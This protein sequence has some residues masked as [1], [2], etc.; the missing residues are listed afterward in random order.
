MFKK[1]LSAL[2]LALAL[3]AA[4]ALPA[5]AE[6]PAGPLPAEADQAEAVWEAAGSNEPGRPTLGTQ[7]YLTWAAPVTSC[8]V[9]QAS[10]YMAVEL[11]QSGKA[12]LVRYFDDAFRRTSY[13]YVDISGEL[14]LYGGFYAG[15]GGSCYLVT[16]QNN[17]GQNDQTEV[18]RVTKYDTNWVRKGAAS[19]RGANTTRPFEAGSLRMAEYG[20][21]LYIRTCHEMYTV[22]GENHQAN[23]T[24][25]V[26]T[27]NMTVTGSAT[28]VSYPGKG[29]ISHS[30]NQFILV[31]DAG[32]LVALDHSDASPR[33]AVLGRYATK[34]NGSNPLGSQY[35]YAEIRSFEG[36][37]GTNATGAS[38]GGLEYSASNYLAAGNYV[39]APTMYFSNVAVRNVFVTATPRSS[40]TGTTTTTWL[41]NYTQNG[42]LT[43]ST[44][45]M[46]KMGD[47]SF[48]VLWEIGDKMAQAQD[49]WK[50]DPMRKLCYAFVNASGKLVGGVH[51]VDGRLSDCKPVVKNGAAVW[52]TSD[53]RTTFYTV[54]SSGAF[55][56]A[57][58]GYS[59]GEM[60]GGTAGAS[61]R[62]HMDENYT[63]YVEG[64]GAVD[65]DAAKQWEAFSGCITRAVI[66][67]GITQIGNTVFSDCANLRTVSIPPSVNSIAGG[68]FGSPAVGFT[69]EGY[70]G[71]EAQRC[72][73]LN[74]Y[75]FV[76]TGALP[77][78]LYDPLV[79]GNTITLEWSS[80]PGVSYYRVFYQLN[81]SGW[82]AA[83]DVAGDGSSSASYMISN[84]APG[85]Y[86]L[87]VCCLREDGQTL[88]SDYSA[89]KTVTVTAQQPDPG[90]QPGTSADDSQVRAFVT[91]LYEV[92][93]GRTPD[94]A[95]LDGWTAALVSHRNTGSQA[96]CGF[97]FSDEFKAKNYCNSCYIDHLYRAFMGREPDTE[98]HAGWMRVLEEEGQSR[99]SVFNGFVGSDEFK[100]LCQQY[101]IDPGTGT[102]EPE[103]VGTVRRGTCA[104]CGATDGVEDFVVRLYRICLD[105]DPDADAQKWMEILRTRQETGRQVAHGFIFSDEF[106]ARGF[107]NETFVQYMYR[108]FFDRMPEGGEESGWVTDLNGGGSRETVMDG[109]TGSD[110]F[111]VLC[112]RYGIRA[113]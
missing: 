31:D 37:D 40:M 68:A 92:C 100:A 41:T 50:E 65:K 73:N 44:P 82:T 103:G 93:L 15:S 46:V 39:Q 98:G 24:M 38:L 64:T 97:I 59:C 12:L 89:G 9:P 62:W 102:A 104:G 16:G 61:L 51:T 11:T 6:T 23:L 49:I 48:L 1:P 91:R 96:A 66:G 10:G 85:T 63:L 34:A 30:N 29:Y 32:N 7:N 47:N 76:A 109:F 5:F 75:R 81:G 55:S 67:S 17:P 71:S 28:G 20:G 18:I 56:S 36:N 107:D 27:S 105:R 84:A 79:Y 88:Y 57:D 77:P 54:S 2:V 86:T 4:A 70:C 87:A 21:Y 111:A 35:T 112:R 42:T 43:T 74:G 106:K 113:Q 78:T 83:G 33:S 80:V 25:Q 69:I 108:A 52:Y 14:P 13:R 72:A 3:C 60:P 110:E 94:D 101:G 19:L 99:E 95:G 8:L 45:Q 53:G 58:G 26:R 22:N 90:T